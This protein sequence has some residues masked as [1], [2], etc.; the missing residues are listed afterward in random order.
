MYRARDNLKST[1][2]LVSDL[3]DV[4]DMT[5]GYYSCALCGVHD[6]DK[7]GFTMILQFWLRQSNAIYIPDGIVQIMIAYLVYNKIYVADNA[8]DES[9]NE[10]NLN[11][12]VSMPI[13][14]LCHNP[15]HHKPIFDELHKLNVED[16][17]FVLLNISIVV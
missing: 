4:I 3:K 15:I 13:P 5:N 6:T 2:E 14:L 12:Y 17:F 8:D 9:W 11:I 1:P 16:Y 10:I 7:H